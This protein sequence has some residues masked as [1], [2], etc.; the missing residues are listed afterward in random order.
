MT[1]FQPPKQARSQATLARFYSATVFLLESKPFEAISVADIVETANASVG[2][3]YKR[4]SSKQALLPAL[5]DWLH[6]EQHDA[7]QSFVDDPKWS[8][9]G[10]SDRVEAFTQALVTSYTQHH[11]LMKA[12]VARQYSQDN[13]QSSS[14]AESAA[15]VIN[16]YTNWL[17]ACRDEI[18]HPNPDTAVALG[19]TALVG[20]LQTRMLFGAHA[21]EMDEATFKRELNRAL[22]A[23]LEVSNAP[24]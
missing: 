5:L 20:Q 21:V 11:Y 14:L 12:L 15:W 6:R 22:L 16:A 2:A 1:R 10:I 7:V 3:F 4:F 9:V 17:L 19:L 13:Q 18:G 8:G 24:D 23:Y